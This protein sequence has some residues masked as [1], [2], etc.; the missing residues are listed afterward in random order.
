[1][2]KKSPLMI[3]PFSWNESSNGSCTGR[4]SKG[5]EHVAAIQ[6]RDGKYVVAVRR[7]VGRREIS[8][9]LKADLGLE[10]A[11]RQL[12]EAV[13][14]LLAMAEN[15]HTLRSRSFQT[16]RKPRS[17]RPFDW[18]DQPTVP[19]RQVPSEFGVAGNVQKVQICYH[20]DGIESSFVFKRMRAAGMVTHNVSLLS[21]Y[22]PALM[23][24]IASPFYAIAR[25]A[26]FH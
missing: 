9:S 6:I 1:M 12:A 5:G 4:V 2:R 18:H 19:D 24:A 3:M 25:R 16:G 8:V 7:L 26:I 15:G 20:A 14:G 10:F 17:F 13:Y 21:V 11:I 23:R 22:R